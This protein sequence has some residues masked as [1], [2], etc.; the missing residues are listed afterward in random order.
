MAFLYIVEALVICAIFFF[1]STVLVQDTFTDI[2]NR[3]IETAPQYA[4][5]V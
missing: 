2:R 4:N 1:A 5:N 3:A